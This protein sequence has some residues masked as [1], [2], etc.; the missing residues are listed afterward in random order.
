MATII[1]RRMGEAF[2]L[3]LRSHIEKMLDGTWVE[4]PDD[5][6]LRL[7]ND[8]FWDDLRATLL[9]CPCG[10]GSLVFTGAQL[11]A[12]CW[13]YC[14]NEKCGRGFDLNHPICYGPSREVS[15]PVA[16]ELW[17]SYIVDRGWE[18]LDRNY[19]RRVVE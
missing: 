7:E 14:D 1:T 5:K 12:T 3:A 18:H 16:A 2:D 19:S 8:K 4:K 9:P 10:G 15:A 6:R 17:N 13:V 11:L